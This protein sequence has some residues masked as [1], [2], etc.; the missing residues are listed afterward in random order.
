MKYKE[1]TQP[2]AVSTFA[3]RTCQLTDQKSQ[4]SF[5]LCHPKKK[6]FLKPLPAKIFKI[7]DTHA[8][9][10]E[11]NKMTTEIQRLDKDHL[12]TFSRIEEN[13]HLAANQI[14]DC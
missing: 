8:R 7:A 3:I 5:H 6:Y 2:T 13:P 10:T 11:T 14:E 9:Q 4:K 12:T 1:L